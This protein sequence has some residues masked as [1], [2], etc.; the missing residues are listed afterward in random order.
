MFPD[1]NFGPMNE[2]LFPY[3]DGMS[4]GL[5]MARRLLLLRARDLRHLATTFK[6]ATSAPEYL[7]RS[8]EAR[9]LARILRGMTK[10]VEST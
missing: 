7:Q 8:I 3:R 9:D 5:R 10:T 2:W 4:R 6:T 1:E